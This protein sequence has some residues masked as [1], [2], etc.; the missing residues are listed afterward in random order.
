[1]RSLLDPATDAV[2]TRCQQLVVLEST[3]RNHPLIDGNKRLGW[4]A[5]V[6]FYGLRAVVIDAPDDEVHDLVIA[7]ATGELPH[8]HVA[9]TVMAWRLPAND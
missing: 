4:L 8:A 9:R 1:M 7:V 3:V 6:V 5:V 2:T